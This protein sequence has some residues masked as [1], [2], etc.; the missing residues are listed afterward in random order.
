MTTFDDRERA[1]EA[2]FAHDAETTFRAE[3]RG[4]KNLGLWAGRALGREGEA[5]VDYA[6]GLMAQWLDKGSAEAIYERIAG[7]SGGALTAEEARARHKELLA[8]AK[9]DLLARE[10]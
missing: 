8:E 10:G 5:C 3:A 4:V 9:A 2:K 1:F 7:D 6:R